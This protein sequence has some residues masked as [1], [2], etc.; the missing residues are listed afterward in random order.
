MNEDGHMVGIEVHERHAVDQD[1]GIP[2]NER[3]YLLRE[4][5]GQTR[6]LGGQ[7]DASYGTS[8]PGRW[9]LS[10]A[11]EIWDE[12]EDGGIATSQPPTTARSRTPHDTTPLLVPK[13][14]QSYMDRRKSFPPPRPP[15]ERRM[16]QRS[17]SS[18]PQTQEA[19]TRWWK[20]RWWTRLADETTP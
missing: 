15:T 1:V 19:S 17:K 16:V 12:L 14:R 7:A 9:R 6:T 3:D 10:E 5:A 4:S 13:S 8:S 18:G 11:D 20:W 2:S